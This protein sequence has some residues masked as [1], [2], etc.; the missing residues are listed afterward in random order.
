V[1]LVW[2]EVSQGVRSQRQTQY[3]ADLLGLDEAIL[4]ARHLTRLWDWAFD[5]A[6]D[7]SLHGRSARTIAQAAGWRG[8]PVALVRSLEQAGFVEG[9][10][11]G[12]RLTRW[13]E[14]ERL[15]AGRRDQDALAGT[16]HEARSLWQA[17]LIELEGMVNRANFQ[18]FLADTV[19]LYRSGT[20]LT[21]GA[22]AGYVCSVLTSRFRPAIDGALFEVAGR[23]LHARV[24]GLPTSGPDTPGA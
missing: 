18:S 4:A 7:G 14:V 23:P 16:P 19:G 9:G 24:I 20:W 22:P 11:S 21:I 8:D 13:P 3:L 12:S 6:P 5:Q 17:A 15:T 10:P 2:G 1:S